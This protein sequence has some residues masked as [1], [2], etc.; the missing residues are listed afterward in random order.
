MATSNAVTNI[1]SKNKVS[2]FLTFNS[3]IFLILY[4]CIAYMFSSKVHS[5]LYIPYMIYSGLMCMYLLLPSKYN[6]GRNHLESICLL[7]K[8]DKSV[9]RP[10]IKGGEDEGEIP[11]KEGSFI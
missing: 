8:N 5:S 3:L 7:F 1:E 2:K 6:K 11:E 10:I 4:L 9:Y